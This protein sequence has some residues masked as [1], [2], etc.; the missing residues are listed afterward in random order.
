MPGMTP[1]LQVP[2]HKYV[3]LSSSNKNSPGV[4]LRVGGGLSKQEKWLY[5]LFQ[6][7]HLW[8][9][10]GRSGFVE[11][12]SASQ[13][14]EIPHGVKNITFPAAYKLKLQSLPPDPNFLSICEAWDKA[15]GLFLFQTLEF[16]ILSFELC[17]SH[18]FKVDTLNMKALKF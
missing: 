13:Y 6:T 16:F 5:S 18:Q 1:Y 2:P 10:S 12:W 7:K 11:V 3:Y 14:V 17:W 15:W 4:N 8:S 9:S